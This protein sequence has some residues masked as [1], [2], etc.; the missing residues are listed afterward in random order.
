[1][2][3]AIDAETNALADAEEQTGSKQLV[4]TYDDAYY[5]TMHDTAKTSDY[6]VFH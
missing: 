1:M 5:K 2:R 3:K 6:G 4:K